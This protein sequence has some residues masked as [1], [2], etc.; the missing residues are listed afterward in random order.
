MPIGHNIH[1][2]DGIKHY[3][4]YHPD[5]LE[6]CREVM[7]ASP[8]LHEDICRAE[9]KSAGLFGD[10]DADPSSSTIKITGKFKGLVKVYNKGRMEKRQKVIADGFK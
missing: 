3:R 10:A 5:E 2:T 7:P 8:F 1:P 6:N 9:K 4:R